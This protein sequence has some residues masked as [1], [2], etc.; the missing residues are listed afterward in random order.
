[1]YDIRQFRPTMYVLLLLGLTGFCLA[2]RSPGLWLVCVLLVGT[3]AWLKSGPDGA[4]KLPPLPG[5]AAGMLALLFAALTWGRFS[6]D[7]GNQ[8]LVAGQF[9][10]ILQLLKLFQEGS[11]NVKAENR[12]YAWILVLSLLQMVA[13]S[14]STASLLFG[15]LLLAYLFTALYCC[16]L[17][18][19]KLE[20]ETA[21][22]AMMLPRDVVSPA[23]LRQDE[24]FLPRSMRRLTVLVA[25][26][27]LSG[28]VV[29]FLFFPRDAGAGLFGQINFRPGQALTGFS[30]EVSF[31][32][33]ARIAQ[34]Q[35]LVAHVELLVNGEAV[36][37]TRPLYLRGVTLDSYTGDGGRGAGWGDRMRGGWWPGGR[38]SGA[39]QWTRSSR[40]DPI[41][42]LTGPGERAEF[43][44]SALASVGRGEARGADGAAGE[45]RS[46]E[47]E[48]E[49]IVA[50][51]K[52]LPTGVNVLFA[53]PG[54][55]GL[56]AT[57]ELR[58]TFSPF[59]E[60]LRSADAV[61]ARLDYTV[62]ARGSI[63]YRA[64]PLADVRPVPRMLTGPPS[65]IDPKVAEYARRPEVSGRAA[66]GTPLWQL[67]GEAY[68]PHPLDG[69]I[70][71]NIERHLQT[72][73][74]YTLDLTDTTR[75]PDVDPIV[76]FLYETRRGHCEY[77]AGAMVLL[78]QSLGMDA[79]MVTGF[80]SEEFNPL[81]GRYVVKQSHAH[82]W[83]EVR[84]PVE[85]SV[86]A[87]WARRGV[88]GEKWLQF[89][90][91][92]GREFRPTRADGWLARLKRLYDYLEFTWADSVV[93]Y[94]RD[95]RDSMMSGMER[96]LSAS[97]V[98]TQQ[99]LLRW[100]Q[101]L[102]D[103][104][105]WWVSPKLVGGVILLMSGLGVAAIVVYACERWRLRRR[106][107]RIGLGDLPGDD[108]LRLARQLG[109]YDEL[110]RVLEQRGY[111]RPAHQTPMEFTLSLVHLPSELYL[112][113]L[114]IT[115]IYYRIRFGRA[116]LSPPYVRRLHEAV[117]RLEAAMGTSGRPRS[118]EA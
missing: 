32:Q 39:W 41:A 5:W 86:A 2:A 9:L 54:A 107:R 102:P 17:F 7:P 79:R 110:L 59:D 42:K 117:Q 84:V 24:R 99:S 36:K 53:P 16:L 45:E 111:R 93:A 112:A 83:V 75:R 40:E 15:V 101:L 105:G 85:A 34:S 49:L 67:R 106:A 50:N 68:G 47:A 8:L 43:A 14:I 55:H 72:E 66:D 65:V 61:N 78:C 51:I 48:G 114:R 71:A 56:Q 21:K 90:P 11:T 3:H 115:R 63:G 108:Q 20:T 116:E 77:F 70:A 22:A 69:T 12:N 95:R 38:G 118:A 26:F 57:R 6:G 109:F 104:G 23:V 81:I 37:G 76:Q 58:F 98:R 87:A 80:R 94:D 1:M 62:F 52:L 31:E 89:D 100:E 46:T 19:L 44:A 33:V 35:E 113:V 4:S 88:V 29:V 96:A 25:A 103:P 18:H 74:A 92:S 73:F 91:T 30:E 28:A 27:G 64:R 82:A 97:A 10:V 60:T 13:A